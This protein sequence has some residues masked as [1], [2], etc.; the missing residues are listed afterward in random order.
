MQFSF[1]MIHYNVKKKTSIRKLKKK[2]E[3]L[4]LINSMLFVLR[5]KLNV[6]KLLFLE[7]KLYMATFLFIIIYQKTLTFEFSIVSVSK[8]VFMSF[9]TNN[10]LLDSDS[11]PIVVLIESIIILSSFRIHLLWIFLNAD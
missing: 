11:L 9:R 2:G 1:S 5:S 10:I 8:Y 6:Q 3:I 4:S 7:Q